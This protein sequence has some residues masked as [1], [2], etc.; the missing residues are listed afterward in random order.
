MKFAPIVPIAHLELASVSDYHMAL[1][2]LVLKYPAYATYYRERR[3]AGDFVLLDNSLIELG[4]PVHPNALVEAAQM[5]SPSEIVLPDTA[6]GLDANTAAFQNAI[7]HEGMQKLRMEGM[8][9]MFVPHGRDLEE[10]HSGVRAAMRS[11]FVDSIG[12]GKPLIGH[13]LEAQVWGRGA[14]V[15]ELRLTVPVHLL[16][17]HTPY[18]LFLNSMVEHVMRGCDSSLPTIAAWHFVEFGGDH[19]MLHRPPDWH[20]DH[21]WVLSDT[22]LDILRKNI[23]FIMVGLGQQIHNC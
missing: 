8:R 6:E 20:Y 15:K 23:K 22:Q 14:I 19:G 4:R 16:S 13:S 1:A 5:I 10:L 21:T 7:R 9:F 12:L 17:F 18:E 2:H 3:K 11:G